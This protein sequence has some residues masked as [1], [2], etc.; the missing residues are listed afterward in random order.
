MDDT[1]TL[2]SLLLSAQGYEVRSAPDGHT[3]LRVAAEFRPQAALLDIGM[4]DM[5]GYEL[6]RRMRSEPSLR[7]ALLIAVTGYGM[8]A[9]IERSRAAGFDHHLV[10][11][12]DFT[13]AIPR[14][15]ASSPRIRR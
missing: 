9:D 4:P 15:L 8:E 2:A 5:D 6:A 13:V 7:D 14:L 11:P 3:A 10:K 1:R 12:V